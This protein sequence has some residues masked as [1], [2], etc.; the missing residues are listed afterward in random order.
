MDVLPLFIKT[1]TGKNH[2]IKLACKVHIDKWGY[3]FGIVC[4][5]RDISEVKRRDAFLKKIIEVS[6]ALSFETNIDK[7]LEMIVD[8]ARDMSNADGGT[9]YILE[10][11]KKH[12][13][14][15]ILQ[16]DTMKTRMVG[17]DIPLPQVPLYI[18]GKPNFSNVSSY[19]LAVPLAG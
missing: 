7:L 5:A 6:K 19:V 14:F 9:L 4:I 13:R 3:N 1:K 15:S 16:N 12:L 11:D 18:E 10:K 2:P 17:K 8:K